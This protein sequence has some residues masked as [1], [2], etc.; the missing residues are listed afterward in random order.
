MVMIGALACGTPVITFRN[1]AAVRS[2]S[3]TSAACC[4]TPSIDRH[5]S[6]YRTL[7]QGHRLRGEPVAG[8]S[9]T[10]RRIGRPRCSVRTVTG[11]RL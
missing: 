11:G 9:T 8:W 5:V 2:S 6:V 1:E 3:T 4:V 10:W 7:A